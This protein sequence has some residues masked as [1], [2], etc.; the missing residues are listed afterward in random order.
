MPTEPE[1]RC[2]NNS[3]EGFKLFSEWSRKV[4]DYEN[5]SEDILKN[6]FCQQNQYDKNFNEFAILQ[7][8]RNLSKKKFIEEI[9]T[10]LYGNKY[11]N[12]EI[13]FNSNI[14]IHQKM[15]KYLMFL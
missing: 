14:F 2:V 4:K 13:K 5:E 15:K 8:T 3:D 9:D 1:I 10:L 11:E 6:H 12:I 7:N